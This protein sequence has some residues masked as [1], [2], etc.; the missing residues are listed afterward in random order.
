MRLNASGDK[1]WQTKAFR[2]FVEE[3]V[4]DSNSG[5]CSDYYLAY[6]YTRGFEG[7]KKVNGRHAI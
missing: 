7:S 1:Q 2:Q 4:M 3:K 6:G 5:S